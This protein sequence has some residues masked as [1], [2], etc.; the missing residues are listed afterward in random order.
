[1]GLEIFERGKLPRWVRMR[2]EL[3]TAT[4][5]DVAAA[6]AEEFARS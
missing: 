5:N 3:V 1:M 2:Q 4:I 6:V